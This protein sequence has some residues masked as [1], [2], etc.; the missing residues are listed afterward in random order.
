MPRF[1]WDTGLLDGGLSSH[2]VDSRLD[3]SPWGTDT[4]SF[5]N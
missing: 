5:W 3:W 2:Q 1:T 4:S